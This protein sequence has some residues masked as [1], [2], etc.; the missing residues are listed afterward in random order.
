[1]VVEVINRVGDWVEKLFIDWKTKYINTVSTLIKNQD[2]DI[3]QSNAKSVEKEKKK[4]IINEKWF[5]YLIEIFHCVA[6][7]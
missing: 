3:I 6:V 1:M 4:F 7:I 2:Q 5:L